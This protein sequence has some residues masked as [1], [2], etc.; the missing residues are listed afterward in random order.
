MKK[1]ISR[2]QIKANLDTNAPMTLIEA[3]PA[4]YFETE[5]LPGALNIP[6][7][8]IAARAPELLT[9]KDALIV[10]YCASS[11]CANSDIAATTLDGLGYTNTQIYKG[12]KS[13]WLEAD[14]PVE[15]TK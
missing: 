14:Y 13:D 3:L 12:G 6:H 9:D 10:V 1:I 5:H 7:E 15:S 4:Q 2:E 8:E 11:T